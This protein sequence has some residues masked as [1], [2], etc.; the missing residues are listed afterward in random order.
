MPATPSLAALFPPQGLVV[1]TGDLTLRPLTDADLPEYAQLLREPIFA[2]P[3]AVHVFAWYAVEPETRIREALRFQWRLRAELSAQKWTLPFGI[4][5][6]DRLIG[7]QDLVATDFAAR[8]VVESGSWLTLSAHGRGYG[9]LMRQ[10]VLV[11][12]FDHLGAQRAESGAAATNAAS[13]AVSHACGYVDNGT[14]ISRMFDPPQLQR[15]FLATP[16]TFRR[17]PVDVEV[18]GLTPAL[19]EMLGADG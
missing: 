14:E 11:L 19:R 1:R 8:R 17:P 10:A 12:A 4:W 13:I 7:C 5:A 16:G 9:K 18:E 3:G 6:D 2:D 15:R